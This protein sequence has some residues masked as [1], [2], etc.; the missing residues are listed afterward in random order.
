MA[1]HQVLFCPF[2]RESFEGQRL[3]PEHE[4]AL[5]SFDRLPAG[6]GFDDEA[7]EP[8]GVVEAVAGARAEDGSSAPAGAVLPDDRPLDALDPRFGRAPVAL[9]A[10][11]N[12][13]ALALP[14]LRS[15]T[16]AAP[17][18]QLARAMPSLWTLLLVSFTVAFTLARR[19]TPRRLRSVRVL[20]PALALVSPLTLLWAFSRLGGLDAP[21]PGPAV[22]LVAVASLLLLVGGARLGTARAR[23]P[24]SGR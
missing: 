23:G 18:Y 4:L 22:Y 13:V 15:T 3:C 6:E 12:L 16:T 9:G 5:V 10:A 20:V 7:D 8:S 21:S 14:L 17:T 1:E 24:S 11:L 2:C 19:R